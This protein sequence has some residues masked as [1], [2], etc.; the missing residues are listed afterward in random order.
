ML[1]VASGP[2]ASIQQRSHPAAGGLRLREE[3]G[4]AQGAG[5]KAPARWHARGGN[6]QL[7]AEWARQGHVKTMGHVHAITG[8]TR[9]IVCVHVVVQ[10]TCAFD[11]LFTRRAH[12]VYG[13]CSCQAHA[14]F[15]CIK[16]PQ[17]THNASGSSSRHITTLDLAK[18]DDDDANTM[19]SR[20]LGAAL[21]RKPSKMP[22]IAA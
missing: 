5:R 19:R 6:V 9:C 18:L 15:V 1:K 16:Q 11:V 7:C 8:Q 20:E 17:E 13:N 4:C 3:E 12:N 14:Q 2:Y 10:Y 21:P 22:P